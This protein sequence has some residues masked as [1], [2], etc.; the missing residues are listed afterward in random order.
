V[1]WEVTVTHL[2]MLVVDHNV[3]RF[4]ISVHDS[5]TVTVIEGLQVVI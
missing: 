4:N 3:V 1:G 5:H 2:S